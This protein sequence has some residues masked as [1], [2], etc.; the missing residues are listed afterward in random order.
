MEN[1]SPVEARLAALAPPAEWQPNTAAALRRHHARRQEQWRRGPGFW[2]K[3]AIAAAILLAIALAPPTRALAQQL[4]RF[5][6]LGRVEV[7]QLNLE[8]IPEGSSLRARI[9][10]H[11]GKVI[12][13]DNAESARSHLG[14]LPRLP[15]SGVLSAAPRLGV[16]GP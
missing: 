11:P 15:R 12:P 8:S 16:M 9:V 10:Q 6:T 13:V 4:W 3:L 5:L 7:M 14:F 1:I 2:W